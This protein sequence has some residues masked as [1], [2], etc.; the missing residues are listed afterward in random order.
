MPTVSETRWKVSESTLTI[1]GVESL[2]TTGRHVCGVRRTC[3]GA[4]WTPHAQHASGQL[5][6]PG[7]WSTCLVGVRDAQAALFNEKTRRS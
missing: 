6:I 4:D 1:F 7:V 5:L 3:I 2:L